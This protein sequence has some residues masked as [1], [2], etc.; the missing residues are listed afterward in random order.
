M[1]LGEEI[2]SAF[3]RFAQRPAI[4]EAAGQRTYGELAQSVH[5]RVRAC[6]EL[7]L[8]P[9]DRVAGFLPNSP[10]FLELYLACVLAN[11]VFVPLNTRLSALELKGILSAAQPK[12]LALMDSPQAELQSALALWEGQTTL[13]RLDADGPESLAPNSVAPSS[14]A[15]PGEL[16]AQLYFTSG[17]TGRAKGVPL[18]HGNVLAHAQAA[19]Q[20]F[21]LTATD[22]WGHFAPMFHLA[23]AWAC[24]AISLAGGAHCFLDSFEAPACFAR[25]E[26][27]GVTVTN[28]V[29]T[30]LQRMVGEPGKQSRATKS[31][32]M[33][34]SGGAPI[35]PELVRRVQERFDCEYVQTYGLTETSPFLTVSLLDDSLRQLDEQQRFF[36]AS[37]T[38]RPFGGIELRLVDQNSAP[39][40]ADGSSVG[41]IQARGPWVFSGY[42]NDLQATQEAFDGDWFR[43]GDLATRESRGFFQIVDRRKDIILSGGE[44]VYS[45]EVENALYTH[46]LVQ[47]AAVFPI[48][49]ETWGELVAAAIVRAPQEGKRQL[50]LPELIAHCRLFLASYKLPRVVY[51]V[52]EFPLTGSGKIQK[53]LLRERCLDLPGERLPS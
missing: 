43:T 2:A 7:G 9:G 48:E 42:W 10:E 32:R 36:Y 21:Q 3:E 1:T 6:N 4:L 29:P 5:A 18:S 44:T 50:L 47:S 37:R 19:L 35:A 33:I 53:R 46:Q 12:V 25:I 52:D 17:T 28:L 40:P 11:L 16:P 41:E 23:D 34:L 15:D 45:T 13:L 49:D 24:F 31:M 22:V 39:V 51:F 30:M 38:G 8:K 27:H 20:E 14:L 26:Q